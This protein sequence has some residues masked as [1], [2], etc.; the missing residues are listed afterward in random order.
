MLCPSIKDFMQ[1]IFWTS[2]AYSFILYRFLWCILQFFVKFSQHTV[3]HSTISVKSQWF[4]IFLVQKSLSYQFWKEK[5]HYDIEW[6]QIFRYEFGKL[7]LPLSQKKK[8]V[9]SVLVID[10]NKTSRIQCLLYI[11][12]FS[13]LFA[14]KLSAIC[15][16]SFYCLSRKLQLWSTVFWK[17]LL[18]VAKR[19]FS[20]LTESYSTLSKSTFDVDFAFWGL[21]SG[22]SFVFSHVFLK[23]AILLNTESLAKT[24]AFTTLLQ[25]KSAHSGFYWFSDLYRIL[26]RKYLDV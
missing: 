6:L 4:R 12:L 18:C 1:N 25:F 24:D 3:L 20:R 9:Q 22:N 7:F 15:P 21:R 26:F 19:L 13:N 5:V 8:P 14:W 10:E 11:L 16:L 2:D 17:W 23:K